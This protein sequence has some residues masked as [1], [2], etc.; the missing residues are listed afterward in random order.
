MAK[1]NDVEII[2]AVLCQFEIRPFWQTPNPRKSRT[3]LC[4]GGPDPHRLRFQKIS[5]R[6]N[7]WT[8]NELTDKYALGA[9][10]ERRAK[11][12]GE[13]TET[14]EPL[15]YLR[16]QP[17]IDGTLRLFD[18]DADPSKIKTKRTYRRV[19]LFGSPGQML[20]ARARSLSQFRRAFSDEASCVETRLLL[21]QLRLN[22]RN[23]PIRILRPSRGKI[24][25]TI[26]GRSVISQC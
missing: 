6:I 23:A 19:K 17:N 24:L 22:D 10:R 15:R 9:F 18:P 1:P 14:E 12:G 3:V 4:N 21:L 2:D 16:R 20:M 5:G 25:L 8:R 13:I 7:S 11:N 26:A